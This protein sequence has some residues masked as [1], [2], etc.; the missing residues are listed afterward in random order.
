MHILP[1]HNSYSLVWMFLGVTVIP[2]AVLAIL[3]TVAHF[4]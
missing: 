3:F 2:T 4:V 1:H